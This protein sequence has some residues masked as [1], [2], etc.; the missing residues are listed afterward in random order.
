[1]QQPEQNELNGTKLQ[2]W[3]DRHNGRHALLYIKCIFE[4]FFVRTALK[5]LWLRN[6]VEIT[7]VWLPASR[8]Q[9]SS[10]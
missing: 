9:A 6:Q 4:E 3:E 5:F 7:N 1:M 10:Y 2:I 8:I